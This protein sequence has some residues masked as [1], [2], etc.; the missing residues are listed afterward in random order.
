M[1]CGPLICTAV[2]SHLCASPLGPQQL[3]TLAAKC[4]QRKAVNHLNFLLLC[5][6]LMYP[7]MFLLSPTT[8]I[9]CMVLLEH[10][11]SFWGWWEGGVGV[12]NHHT[13]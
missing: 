8:E 6:Y 4:Q 11:F 9:Y 2:R 3:D 10:I 13:V 1:A 7:S 12:V 5:M